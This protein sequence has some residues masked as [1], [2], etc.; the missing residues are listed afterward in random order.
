MSRNFVILVSFVGLV[1][2]VPL[3]GDKL[4][5]HKDHKGGINRYG[6]MTLKK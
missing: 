5:S 2:N 4:V 6:L 1:R 3:A